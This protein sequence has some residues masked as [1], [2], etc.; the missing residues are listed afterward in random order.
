MKLTPL[1]YAVILFLLIR[2]TNDLPTG[3]NYLAHSWRFIAIELTGVLAAC[4]LCFYLANKWIKFSLRH[5][6]HLIAEYGAVIMVPSLLSLFVMAA[7]HDISLWEEVPNL[8]IPVVIVMLMSLGLYVTQKNNLLDKMYTEAKIR[9]QEMI[10]AKTECDLKMLRAQFHPHFLFNM[11]NTLY[12]TIDETNAK[13]RETVEH[14]ASLLRYQL[15]DNQGTVPIEREIQAM[16]SYIAL[17]R[18]RF[19]DTVEIVSSIDRRFGSDLIYPHM[20]LPLVENAFKHSGEGKKIICIKLT[21]DFNI[22][23]LSVEN[24]VPEARDTDK[25]VSGI[26]LK[27]IRRTLELMYK[28]RYEFSAKRDPDKY[29]TY[30]KIAL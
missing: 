25:H 30:L 14:M 6:V 26:G 29:C 11:L 18:T 19:E 12:F 10:N 5:R 9:E 16:E 17:Y 1:I 4:Y 24:S 15:Y 13:A 2:L 23:E 27:N 8:I 7:S 22:V 21:R 28:G 20:L 3:S